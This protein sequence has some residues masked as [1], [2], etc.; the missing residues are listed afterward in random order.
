MADEL[1]Y[2]SDQSGVRVSDKRL[3]IGSTT[4]SMANITTIVSDGC[5]GSCMLAGRRL[6]GSLCRLARGQG[7]GKGR[8]NVHKG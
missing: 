2:C 3:I 8:E 6:I 1:S 5:D 4:Y 7:G